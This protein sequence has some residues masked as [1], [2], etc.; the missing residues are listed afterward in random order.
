MDDNGDI[1]MNRND[2]DEVI[3]EVVDSKDKEPEFKVKPF[4]LLRDNLYR[5]KIYKGPKQNY[6]F[7]DTHHIVSDGTSLAVL[8]D[9]INR[10]YAGECI[11]DPGQACGFA[12][13]RAAGDHDFCDRHFFSFS[14]IGA[15]LKGL[16]SVS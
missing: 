8:V 10:A 9:D 1:Y 4:N 15:L 12:G 16:F 2:N 6:L 14:L 13:T 7:M 11:L 5:I 3:I